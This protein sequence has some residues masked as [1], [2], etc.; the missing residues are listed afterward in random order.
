MMAADTSALMAVIMDENDG[1]SFH[2]A[3]RNDG[4]VLVST[5]TAVEFLIV[6]MGRGDAIYQAAVQL[7]ERPFI[8][9]TP[10]DA[11]QSW[12]AAGAYLEYGKG[13]RNSAQLNYGDTFSYALASARGCLFFTRDT[14]S[15]IRTSR[16]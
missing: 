3:M 4:E 13:R 8:Q 2:S 12:L 10:L 1:S 11:E 6:A 15:Q 7:L 9:L 14:I 5:A 16:R